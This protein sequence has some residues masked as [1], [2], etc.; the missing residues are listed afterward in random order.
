[1]NRPFVVCHMLSSLDGKIDGAFF[2]APECKPASTEYGAI[3]GFYGCQATL[4]GTTTMAGSYS[5]G[6][7]GEL[8]GAT[9]S[10]PKEDYIAPSDVTNYIVSLDPEGV[11]G[12]QSN[13]IEKKGR[14]KAHVIE[15]LTE[16][17]SEDYLGYLRSFDISYLFAGKDQLDLALLLQKLKRYYPIERLMIAGGGIVNWSFLQ[18]GLIDELSLVLAP[19]ADGSNTAVS[20]FEQSVFSPGGKPVAFALKEIKQIDGNTLW[21]RY[22]AENARTK[23]ADKPSQ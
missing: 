10:Y 7:A 21:L 23:E 16:R 1:M 3:R 19:I 5:D 17:V 15:I 8:P 14:L 6:Y 11:L 9:I 20:I 22:L 4:Y 2:A 13:Y 12:W 18:A